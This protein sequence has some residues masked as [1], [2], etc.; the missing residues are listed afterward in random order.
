M[1]GLDRSSRNF[2]R[3]AAGMLAAAVLAFAAGEGQAQQAATRS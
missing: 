3:F 1:G 2:V